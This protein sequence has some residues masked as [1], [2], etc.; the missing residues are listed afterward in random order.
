[1]S[2]GGASSRAA[3]GIGGG[4]SG[5]EPG[6]GGP[7]TGGSTN[8]AGGNPNIGGGGEGGND[9]AGGASSS[10][11]GATDA[12]SGDASVN[13]GGHAAGGAAATGGTGAAGGPID[14]ATDAGAQSPSCPRPVS[15]VACGAM[16][17]NVAAGVKC[18][19]G[20][21]ASLT[22]KCAAST[23]LC[24]LAVGCD[25]DKDCGT[26]NVCCATT[27]TNT[28]YATQ[29]QAGPCG[30]TPFMCSRPSDCSD[31]SLCCGDYV[32]F[33]GTYVYT[34]SRCSTT[35]TGLNKTILC[36]ASSV[37]PT[38]KTCQPSLA[39]QPGFTDCR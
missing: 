7:G 39:V 25:S 3:G 31:G 32:S 6:S 19:G 29:C 28:L 37:C 27:S 17:C 24:V 11:G 38:G 16:S 18:C 12:G 20:S 22:F 8:S 21:L 1:V 10:S 4:A 30:A 33:L 26:G 13:G 34:A 23:Q 5:G 9:A 35:C 14:C 15:T 36:D 2:S